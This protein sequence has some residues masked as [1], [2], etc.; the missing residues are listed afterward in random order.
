M[1]IN[2]KSWAGNR[3][4]P[5]PP[6]ANRRNGSRSQKMSTLDPELFIKKAVQTTIADYVPSRKIADLP[7]DKRLIVN[8]TRKGYSLPTEIQ[9]KTL[10]PI[11]R[12]S[13]R[14]SS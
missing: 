2:R 14:R 11:S 5:V 4:K 8:L 12:K 6:K 3:S 9:D 7:I 1:Q 10:A 13:T